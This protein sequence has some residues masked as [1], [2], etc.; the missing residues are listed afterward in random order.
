M[1]DGFSKLLEDRSATF[2][3]SVKFNPDG[4]YIA[5][6][7]LD[8][9]VRIWSV[10][11]G[12]LVEKWGHG[13]TV[14]SVAFT[15]DGKGLVSGSSDTWKYWDIS[16]L[17]ST[18]PGYA[19]TKDSTAGQKS[20]VTVHT[21]RH[22]H[23]PVQLFLLTQVYPFLFLP[24]CLQNSVSSIAISPDGPSGPTDD[25]VRI[26][27]L[28]NAALKCTLKGHRARVCSV[29]I[30]PTGNYLASSSNDGQVVLWRYEAA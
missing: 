10:R 4:R 29:E 16:L 5:A 12:Q 19:K 15:P 17:E 9:M 11:T 28:R 1:R 18:K 8:E 2:F 30:C 7:N 26:W 13:N 23:V 27:A 24:F 3:Y 25:T 14:Q 6:G 21:V 20:K 22:P